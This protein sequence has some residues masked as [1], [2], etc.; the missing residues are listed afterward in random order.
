MED[1]KQWYQ[2]RTIWGA[3]IAIAASL[4]HAGGMT[5]STADQGQ[6]VDSLVSASGALGGL[7]AIYGRMK[8]KSSLS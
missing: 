4:A 7:V 8:A 3:L 6:I 5:V 1:I 2:S